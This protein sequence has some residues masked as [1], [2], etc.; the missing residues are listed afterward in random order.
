MNYSVTPE[1][2]RK[3]S[4]FKG[5]HET[6]R[7]LSTLLNA[8]LLAPDRASLLASLD[9]QVAS[10]EG[11]VLV[12]RTGVLWVFFS[13]GEDYVLLVDITLAAGRTGETLRS[14]KDPRVDSRFNP[15]FNSAI[16]PNFNSAINPNFNS[17]INPNFNSAINP[18]FNSAIN[19]NFNSAINPNFNSAI[20][21]NFNSA[22]NPN[23]NSAINPIYNSALNPMVNPSYPGPYIYR[24]NLT[25]EGFLVRANSQVELVFNER[26]KHEGIIVHTNAVD[27]AL[28]FDL[29]NSWSG[30]MVSNGQGGFSRFDKNCKWTSFVV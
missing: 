18:N 17:A 29:R 27:V 11:G 2:S 1:F 23:F 19:P 7:Q 30:F 24:L 6:M 4:Q 28:L 21:P 22:I 14:L 12:F 20:N 9:G 8:I 3:A 25:R 10:L 16:N 5:D 13:L 26:A 15:N